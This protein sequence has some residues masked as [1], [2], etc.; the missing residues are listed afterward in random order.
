MLANPQRVVPF[1]SVLLNE[2]FNNALDLDTCLW[3]EPQLPEGTECG[4]APLPVELA[5]QDVS[6]VS[7]DD[8]LKLIDAWMAEQQDPAFDDA[9]EAY[10]IAFSW[11]EGS[12]RKF[13]EV[14]QDVAPRQ[15]KLPR[16]GQTD[17]DSAPGNAFFPDWQSQTP[18]EL[19]IW[20]NGALNTAPRDEITPRPIS[21]QEQQPA[22]RAAVAEPRS[23]ASG[24]TIS[25]VALRLPQFKLPLNDPNATA[26]G[27]SPQKMLNEVSAGTNLTMARKAALYMLWNI[28]AD[29]RIEGIPGTQV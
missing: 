12:K 9:L 26:S 17:E 14:G 20:H 24:D 28:N 25:G 23:Q 10:N 16:L 13:E 19:G 21:P 2:A 22:C 6:S 8:G 27:Q 29:S 18:L 7:L 1:D 11:P 5:A 4:V 15:A 3:P